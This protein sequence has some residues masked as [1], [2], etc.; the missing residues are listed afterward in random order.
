[1]RGAG[2]P[3]ADHLIAVVTDLATSLQPPIRLDEILPRITEFSVAT[4]P[5][6]D[7]AS[8]SIGFKVGS[9]HTL[10][11]T[12]AIAVRADQLQYDLRQGPCVDTAL[13][14]PVV[15]VDELATDLR[16]PTYARQA[17]STLGLGSQLANRFRVAPHARGTLNLYADRPYMIDLD[18]RQLAAMFAQLVGVAI[19][20][21]RQDES[22]TQAVRSHSTIGQAIGIVME[23]YHLDPDHAFGYIVRISQ[24]SNTKARTIAEQIITATSPWSGSRKPNIRDKP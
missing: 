6:I 22:M 13:D 20:W 5:G 16:W 7:H 19:A 3:A 11:P 10:A 23:R 14:G 4:I 21:A 15:Q 1:M 12:S 2:T 18:T 24:R 8:I 9:I 17:A